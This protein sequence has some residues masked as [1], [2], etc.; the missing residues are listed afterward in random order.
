MSTDDPTSQAINWFTRMREDD[1][2]VADRKR[3]DEWLAESPVHMREYLQ[4]VDVW[5]S[6]HA[7]DERRALGRNSARQRRER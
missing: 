2:T 3:F 1:L 6:L 5:G 4:I 7:R